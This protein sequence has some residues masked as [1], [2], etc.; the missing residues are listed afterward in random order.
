MLSPVLDEA[1]PDGWEPFVEVGSGGV[2]LVG[3][4]LPVQGEI[5][6]DDVAVHVLKEAN[7]LINSSFKVETRFSYMIEVDEGESSACSAAY[8]HIVNPGQNN[9]L[10]ERFLFQIG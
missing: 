10:D 3:P 2:F 5:P 6:V 7:S 1:G 4:P 8:T 9:S